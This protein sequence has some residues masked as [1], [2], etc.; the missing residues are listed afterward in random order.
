MDR[1]FFHRY[2]SAWGARDV[3][4][5]MAFFTDDVVFRDTTTGHG[6]TGSAK[7][8]RFAEA[9]FASYP[10]SHFEL[11]THVCD[12]TTFAMEWVMRPGDIPG[13]SFG[14]II[15]GRIAEQ[16]DYWDG[17]LLP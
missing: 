11:R 4:A 14:R 6:A 3:D 8:R 7:M 15:D 12:G 16:R 13:V 17:R 2:L 9:S 10:D 1:S 5:L